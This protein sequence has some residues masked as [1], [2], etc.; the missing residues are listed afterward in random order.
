MIERMKIQER[1]RNMVH[2]GDI[3]RNCISLDYS[4]NINPL[5]IPA[6]VE[7]ALREAVSLCSR[8]PDIRQ[9]KLKAAIAGMDKV[10]AD[11]ILCGNGASELF[12]AILHAL[13]PKKILIPVP[14]FYGYEW[15]AGTEACEV[16]YFP[17][18]EQDNFVLGEDFI[19]ALDKETELIYLANP[20][21]PTGQLI[22]P[23]ILKGILKRCQELDIIVVVEAGM[24]C[25]NLIQV[26]AFTKTFAIPGVRLG[27]LI[28]RNR[29]VCQKI[30][31]QLPEW[32]LSVFA[33]MA[34]CAAAKETEFIGESR[35]LIK[36]QRSILTK[37][38][39]SLG[40]RVYPSR[41]DYILF[42]TELPLYELLL[43]KQILIR[44][45]ENYRGLSKGYYRIAVRGQAENE[46]LI[47]A[48]REV[49][50]K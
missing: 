38:L 4:V 8:Y 22:P 48:L 23:E 28:C 50:G 17:L 21:N 18:R 31:R 35:K 36:E 42:Y 11:E 2:G 26:R 13:K 40:F 15:A 10:S 29:E 19:E 24:K 30:A 25:G 14:S 9:E 16:S 39:T 49:M 45:C 34:G 46:R 7:A 6:S 5:G 1:N 41:A 3:Y 37:E 32:N 27:Y 44:N 47:S 43:K 20:N 12:P 33:Q